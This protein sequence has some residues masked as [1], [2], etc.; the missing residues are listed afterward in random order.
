[1]LV[2]SLACGAH[3]DA[4]PQQLRTRATAPLLLALAHAARK[5]APATAFVLVRR[6]PENAMTDRPTNFAHLSPKNE[7][8]RGER[9]PRVAHRLPSGTARFRVAQGSP[10]LKICPLAL[11]EFT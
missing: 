7:R 8:R 2:L 5:V 3:D 9:N 11:R 10:T 4:V 6:A 1:M